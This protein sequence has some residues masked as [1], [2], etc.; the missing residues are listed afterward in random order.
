L[1]LLDGARGNRVRA[2]KMERWGQVFHYHIHQT[3]VPSIISHF[4]GSPIRN[5]LRGGS[6]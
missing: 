6:D 2:R 3:I 4:D 5:G 1:A